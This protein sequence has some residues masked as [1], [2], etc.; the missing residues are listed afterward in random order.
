MTDILHW[1]HDAPLKVHLSFVYG[2]WVFTVWGELLFNGDPSEPWDSVIEA[3][4]RPLNVTL[5]LALVLVTIPIWF[6]WSI[7]CAMKR[8]DSQ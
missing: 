2:V 5:G 7:Y 6:P 4:A 8:Q 1:I 3:A